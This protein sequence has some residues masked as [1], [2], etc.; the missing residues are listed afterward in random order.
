MRKQELVHLHSLLIEITQ[1]LVEQGV[2]PPDVWNEYE[3]LDISPHSIHAQKSDHKEAVL[4]LAATLRVGLKQTTDEQSEI[5]V[6]N[7]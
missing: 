1:S 5:S 2:V 7:Q 3:T 6:P 4:L